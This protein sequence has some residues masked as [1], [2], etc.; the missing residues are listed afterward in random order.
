[1]E[2]VHA[3]KGKSTRKKPR[4]V[5]N[6]YIEIPKEF[7]EAHKGAIPFVDILYIDGVIFLLTLSENIMVRLIKIRYRKEVSLLEA[8]DDEFINC[9]RTGFEIN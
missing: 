1:M 9:N 3:P 8:V 6:D 2:S 5:V 7:I 4:A